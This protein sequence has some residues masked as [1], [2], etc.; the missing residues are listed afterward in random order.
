MVEISRSDSQ[1]AKCAKNQLYVV[2]NLQD[3][4]ANREQSESDIQEDSYS[5]YYS[6]SSSSD[7]IVK[8][9]AF[10]EETLIGKK[11]SSAFIK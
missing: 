4:I 9:V 5:S 7:E 2:L 1:F 6:E 10:D 8:S 3:L 11:S